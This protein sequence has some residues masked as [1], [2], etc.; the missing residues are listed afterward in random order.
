MA[1]LATILRY[2]D[3]GL[4]GSGA[5]PR[6]RSFLSPDVVAA[7]FDRLA[8]A[9][10]PVV[11]VAAVLAALTGGP[12][13]PAGAV[14]LTFDGALAD[15]HGAILPLLV[16]RGLSA[17]FHLPAAPIRRRRV[18]GAHKLQFV[19][20]RADTLQDVT[21]A[22]FDLVAEHRRA[23][24]ALPHGVALWDDLAA[25][26]APR[27]LAERE[28]MFVNRLLRSGLP[29]AV[30]GAVVDRLFQTFVTA[31]EAEFAAGLY[32]TPAQAAALAAAGMEVGAMG[33]GADNLQGLPPATQAAEVAQSAAF[34]AEVAGQESGRRLFAYPAGGW[35]EAT[36][37]LLPAHGFAAGLT[38]HRAPVTA[39]SDPLR[40]PRFDAARDF[41]AVLAKT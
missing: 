1:P 14:V 12:A 32:L 39:G 23:G 22:V 9:G 30:R 31:D 17:A 38:C 10:R 24:A 5:R 16:A 15:H 29:A 41:D 19:L 33:D 21:A 6:P 40:L 27:D 26:G 4:P 18:A 2:R 11:R 25:V 36:L 34:L 37:E 3:V 7:Q 20:A 28:A 13:L 35:D 8:A